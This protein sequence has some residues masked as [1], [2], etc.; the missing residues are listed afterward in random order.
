M[1]LDK[2]LTAVRDAQNPEKT[3]S[4]K[5]AAKPE[6]KT[7]SANPL[8]SAMNAAV[9]A[10]PA[11]AEKTA[12]EKTGPVEDVMKIAEDVSKLEKEAAVKEAQVL[13]AA[14]ADAAIARISEWQK[15]A[16]AMPA[17]V[18]APAPVTAKIA[19]GD[20]EFDKWASENE[21][22][23]KQATEMGYPLNRAGMQKMADDAYVAG[24]NDT[25]VAIHKTAALEF[26]KGAAVTSRVIA[27]NRQSA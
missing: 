26:L 24:Y 22:T 18:A 1:K 7:A 12:S 6:E 14:F 17:P 19:T 11:T 13:G 16:A 5:P 2:I 4:E 8:V 27:A 21:D 3:A 9:A 20:A 10:A 25:V 23:I 15:T